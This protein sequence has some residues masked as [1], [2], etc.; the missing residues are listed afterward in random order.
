M[1]ILTIYRSNKNDSTRDEDGQ[2][3]QVPMMDEYNK[4]YY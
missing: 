4:T 3:F 1:V 2:C